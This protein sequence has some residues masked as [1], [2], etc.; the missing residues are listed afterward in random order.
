M[1]W[2]NLIDLNYKKDKKKGTLALMLLVK[3]Y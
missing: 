1:F 2:L 3:F